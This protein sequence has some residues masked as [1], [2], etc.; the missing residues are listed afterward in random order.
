MWCVVWRLER[1]A[2]GS[3]LR[4]ALGGGFDTIVSLIISSRGFRLSAQNIDPA[5]ILQMLACP[6]I[7][8]VFCCIPVITSNFATWIEIG[9]KTRLG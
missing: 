9:V 1:C 3:Q 4:M 5:A 8:V 6:L 2:V 7:I